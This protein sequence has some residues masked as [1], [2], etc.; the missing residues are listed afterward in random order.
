MTQI[1]KLIKDAHNCADKAIESADK[2][3]KGKATAVK[4]WLL[5]DAPVF[6]K[7]HVIADVLILLIA[8]AL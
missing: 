7:W 4:Q 1:E 5:S 8:I 3:I 6:K 2:R